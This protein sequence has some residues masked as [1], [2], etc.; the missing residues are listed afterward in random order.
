VQKG[1]S[2]RAMAAVDPGPGVFRLPSLDLPPPDASSL[3]T[4]PGIQPRFVLPLLDEYASGTERLLGSLRGVSGYALLPGTPSKGKGRGKERDLEPDTEG[5]GIE[6]AD[7]ARR[8]GEVDLWEQVTSEE[9]GPSRP[10]VF[11]VCVMNPASERPDDV[12][13][14]HQT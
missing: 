7:E 4:L 6:D 10:K 9:A 11:Q 1:L 2:Y 13:F 14:A 5:D 8:Q 12:A 3:P